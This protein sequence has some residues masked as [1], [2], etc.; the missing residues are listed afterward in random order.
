MKKFFVVI[1]FI[2]SSVLAITRKQ[3]C[4]ERS[5]KKT[6]YRLLSD[7]IAGDP[8]ADVDMILKRMK[9]VSQDYKNL[10]ARCKR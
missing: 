4:D 7:K 5:T 8:H 1:L 3:A 2:Q 6:E 9:T 10:E